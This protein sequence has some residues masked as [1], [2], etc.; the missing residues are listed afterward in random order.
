MVLCSIAVHGLS[1]PFFSLGRRVHS[2]SR[3]WS[4]HDTWGTRHS[5]PALPEWTTHT[6]RV[7]RAEDIIINRD[8]EMERGSLPPDEKRL[9]SRHDSLTAVEQRG[10]GS[11]VSDEKAEESPTTSR[12]QDEYARTEEGGGDVRGETPPDGTEVMAEWK[13]GHDRIVER[14]AGPGEEVRVIPFLR[15]PPGWCP[16]DMAPCSVHR[17]KSKFRKTPLG[18][19]RCLLTLSEWLKTLLPGLFEISK[20]PSEMLRERLSREWN[21][22]CSRGHMRLSARGRRL[23]TGLE[24]R[25]GLIRLHMTRKRT[26]AG[27]RIIVTEGARLA[28]ASWMGRDVLDPRRKK[29]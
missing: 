18:P 14:R 5:Q 12:E 29:L 24:M 2:V 28:Y 9:S 16:P 20:S 17:S 27:C 22:V 3:T 11:A 10:E 21:L 25:W 6:R 1:I 26:K 23:R 19:K 7:V 13:E 8:S 4:R 15:S